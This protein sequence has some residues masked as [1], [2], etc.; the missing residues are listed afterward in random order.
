MLMKRTIFIIVLML[1]YVAAWGAKR[2]PPWMNELPKAGN[3]TIKYVREVGEGATLTDAH[4]QALLRVMQNSANRIGRP[5]DINEVDKALSGS[6]DYQAISRQYNIPVNK[7]DQY[8]EQLRNGTY[9]VWVLC[10]VAVSGNVQPQWEELRRGGEVNN[11][12]S[13]AKSA[14]VP[15]L[16]QIGKGYIAEGVFTLGGELLLVGTGVG[17]Y[18]MAQ[19]QLEVMRDASTAYTDWNSASNT[20][21]TLQTISYIAWGAAAVLY[22]FNLYRAFSMQPKHAT[23]IAFAPS[24]LPSG[25]SLTPTLSLT[26]NF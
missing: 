1:A 14:V 23:G 16:G 9:R 15:G 19:K 2:L 21:N 5:F 8:E 6:N 3:P 13:L 12:T 17:S 25:E 10:Q 20:Y 18:F 7:V 22:A 4:N 11:W 24:L 26:F